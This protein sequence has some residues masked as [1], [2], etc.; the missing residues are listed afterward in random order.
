M[1]KRDFTDS[2]EFK[3]VWCKRSFSPAQEPRLMCCCLLC[4]V[5]WKIK[6]VLLKG[7]A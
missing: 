1:G 5:H 4:S 3:W 7:L 6:L 2:K